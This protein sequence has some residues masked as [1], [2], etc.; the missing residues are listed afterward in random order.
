MFFREESKF[1]HQKKTLG[2]LMLAHIITSLIKQSAGWPPNYHKTARTFP[3]IFCATL[4]NNLTL[5]EAAMKAN[6]GQ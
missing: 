5:N 4:L 3:Q 6:L 1:L 2:R